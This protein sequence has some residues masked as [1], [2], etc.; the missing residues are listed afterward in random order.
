M[1][2]YGILAAKSMQNPKKYANGFPIIISEYIRLIIL[3]AY[4]GISANLQ[5]CWYKISHRLTKMS[6]AR[7][8]SYNRDQTGEG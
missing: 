1:W 3:Y 4:L 8:C 5:F 7:F 2:V 6:E